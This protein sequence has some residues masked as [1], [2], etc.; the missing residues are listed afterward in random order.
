VQRELVEAVV[1]TGTPVVL[2]LLTG[3]PYAIR[4]AVESC[5]AV[6]QAFFPGEEGAGAVAGIL[7]GRV[8]PS[9]RLPV[10]LPSSAG[11]QP[12]SYLHPPLGGASSVSSVPT[13]PVLPFGHGLGYTTFSYADLDLREVEVPTDGAITVT[14]AV[15]NDGDRAGAEVV[16]LYGHDVV[17]SVTRPVAQLL[18]Y[19]RVELAPGER[20]VV[21][22][23]VP[24]TRLAFSDR[25]LRR[26]VEP[27]AVDVWV[28]RSCVDRVLEGRVTLVGSVHPVTVGDPRCAQVDVVR[29]S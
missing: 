23:T 17:G 21:H 14:V 4:W 5:A 20:A 15:R 26:V 9:G 6:L 25:S 8:N 10:S 28:G 19:A 22:L 3:R 18:A 27:G 2:V 16:Q 24:T 1:A 13:A 29:G 11:T 12:Y 7:S